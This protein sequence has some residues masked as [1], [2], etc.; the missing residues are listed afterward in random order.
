V[1]EVRDR[2]RIAATPREVWKVLCEIERYADWGPWMRFARR[3]DRPAG[4][5]AAYDER[6]RLLAPL[7]LA[8]RWR[9]IEFDPPRR[10]VHRAE[11]A[12]LAAAYDR[13]FELSSDGGDGT[14][15]TLRLEYR[16]AL[17]PIGRLLDGAAL[18]RAQA[19]RVPRT[20]EAIEALTL[21]VR[22]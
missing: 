5:G 20:L 6:S 8:S 10:Q 12:P 17:G 7:V 13:V 19:R 21:G 4:L 16:P 18:R 1:T 11:T 22:G 9:I 15:L 2:R 3:V 14:W